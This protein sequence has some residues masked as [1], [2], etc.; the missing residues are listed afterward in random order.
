LSSCFKENTQNTPQTAK[1][2]KQQQQ[3]NQAMTTVKV[4]SYGED[5]NLD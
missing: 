1:P 4:Y 3:Q 2:T 5:R